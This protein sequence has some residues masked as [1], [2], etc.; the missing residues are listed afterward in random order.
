MAVAATSRSDIKVKEYTYTWEGTRSLESQD[1]RRNQGRLG[2][3]R[4]HESASAGRSRRQGQARNLQRRAEGQRTRHHVLHASAGDDAQGRRP[5][6]A[7]I[8]DRR[9]RPQQRALLAAR[10]GHQDPGRNRVQPVAV[11]PRAPRAFRQSLLQPGPGRRNGGHARRDPREARDVQGK[12]PRDQEQDQIG[13]LLSDFG[14]RRRRRRDLGHH[15]LRDS[16]VQARSS[17]ASAPIF[18]PRRR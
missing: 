18:P 5:A 1:S 9:P 3:H 8:R 6:A 7:V 16:R 10:H 12:D 14:H 4:P 11:V 13:P 17:R 2:D 15:G